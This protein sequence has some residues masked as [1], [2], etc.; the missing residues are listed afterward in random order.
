MT[1]Q[2]HSVLFWLNMQPYF[3][4]YSIYLHTIIEFINILN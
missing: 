3:K 2:I 4:V 1:A